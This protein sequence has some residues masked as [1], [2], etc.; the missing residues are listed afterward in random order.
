MQLRQERIGAAGVEQDE[1]ELLGAVD[2]RHD[3]VKR[4]GFGED[5]A[6]VGELGIDRNEKV[7]AKGFHAVARII[8]H[9]PIG[10]RRLGR[11]RAQRTDHLVAR[12]VLDERHLVEADRAQ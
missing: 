3:L 6:G 1:L 10:L 7:D 8:D 5:V 4:H 11:K 12:A 9:R 2:G